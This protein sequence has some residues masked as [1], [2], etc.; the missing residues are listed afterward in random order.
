[1][2]LSTADRIKRCE[3]DIDLEPEGYSSVIDRVAT[4]EVQLFNNVQD[5]GLRRRLQNV[6]RELFE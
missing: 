4:L 5:G 3:Q 6:E 1:M 2:G